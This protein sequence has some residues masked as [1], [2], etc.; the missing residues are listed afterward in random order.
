[1]HHHHHHE[2]EHDHENDHENTTLTLAEGD[3]DD[4]DQ[5]A[6]VTLETPVFPAPMPIPPPLEGEPAY[7]IEARAPRRQ[8][9]LLAVRGSLS[10]ARRFADGVHPS[11]ADLIIRELPLP[12]DAATLV[13]AMAELRTWSRQADGRWSPRIDED[14]ETVVIGA[15]RG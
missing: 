1:M 2:H 8:P 3:C 12:C 7:L 6:A 14:N 15:F 9:A 13:R 11:A 4:T 10:A 5:V